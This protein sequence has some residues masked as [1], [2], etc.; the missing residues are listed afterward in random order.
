M[1]NYVGVSEKFLDNYYDNYRIYYTINS[2]YIVDSV[3]W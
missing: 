1:H 2:E 3:G